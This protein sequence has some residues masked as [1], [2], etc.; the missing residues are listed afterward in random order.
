MIKFIEVTVYG[1]NEITSVNID[2]I[3]KLVNINDC[4]YK[5]KCR[6]ETVNGLFIIV[7]ESYK[8]ILRQIDAVQRKG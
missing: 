7:N 6:I 8:E 1:S 3:T 2:H 4:K 5:G